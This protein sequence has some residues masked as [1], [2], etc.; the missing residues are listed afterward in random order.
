[1][2]QADY[3]FN[4]PLCSGV[5]TGMVENTIGLDRKPVPSDSG[6]G[7]CWQSAESFSYWFRETPG[8]N[9]AFPYTITANWN[10]NNKAYEYNNP[11]FFPLDGR[12]YGNE[13]KGHNF[14]FCLEVHSQFTY[15]GGEVYYFM[16]DDDVWVFINDKLVVDLGGVHGPADQTCYLDDLG[17]EIG[18]TYSFDFFFCERHVT[19][20]EMAFSTTVKLDPCGTEDTD[21][22][23]IA[24]KCDNCPFGDINLKFGDVVVAGKTVNFPF[25]VGTTIRNPV[26]V[27]FDFGDGE[28]T[29]SSVSVDSTVSHTYAKQGTYTVTASVS[30]SGCGSDTDSVDTKLGNRKAPTCTKTVI[31]P[32]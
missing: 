29:T 25:T 30:A 31:I 23:G 22:D 6:N 15:V 4:G 26:D 24:D 7:Y 2:S 16:G 18:Y 32:Q 17:L 20:S 21:S 1:M 5:N 9:Q 19:G 3:D 12:G 10:E 27:V 11:Q 28:T 14:G 8:V 13:N